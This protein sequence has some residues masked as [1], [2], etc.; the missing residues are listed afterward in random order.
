MICWANGV[1]G[2]NIEGFIVDL[3]SK[4]V[5]IEKI[6]GKYSL[7]SVQNCTIYFENVLI[8]EDCKLAKAENFV[9]GAGKVLKHSRVKV[10]WTAIGIAVGAYDHCIKYISQRK[11]FGKTVSSF[12]LSQEKLGRMM[13]NIQAM[14]HFA[15]RVTQLYYKGKATM[16]QI[17]LWKAWCTLRG[18]EVVALARE[19]WG[20]NGII[21]D[22]G[23]MKSFIDM[24]SI[25][26]YE[27]TYD[28]NVQFIL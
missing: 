27:G 8:P 10:S 24:E 23:V 11:Q 15:A 21:L 12:Q 2:K 26:T 3:K 20:G 5:K 17:A 4:G 6:E 1:S 19:L 14:I 16:G 9:S 13:G 28:I 7:R 18:R 25:Y 22:N